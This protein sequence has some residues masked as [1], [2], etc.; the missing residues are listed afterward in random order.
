MAE[1]QLR[2]G[3]LSRRTFI[4]G[5]GAAA[6][7]PALATELM[8]CGGAG[9]SPAS[10]T[11]PA[12]TTPVHM[13]VGIVSYNPLHT[14]LIVAHE[15]DLMSKHNVSFDFTL[16]TNS[17]AMVAALV[18]GSVDVATASPESMF[19]IQA[20]NQDLQTIMAEDVGSGYSLI[21]RPEIGSISDLKGKTLGAS[22]AR[23]GP[24]T[25]AMRLML[26][27]HGLID[28]QD[29]SIIVIGTVAERVSAMKAKQVVAVAN[30]QPQVDQMIDA[31]F[32]V[33][34]D[35][36]NY[37]E[38]KNILSLV[39]AAKK[40][41]YQAHR[42]D[43]VRFVKGYVDSA[44]FVN[45]PA[46][47]DKVVAVLAKILKVD[48]RMATDAYDRFVGNHIYPSNPTVQKSPMDQVV[49]NARTLGLPGVPSDVTKYY[50]NSLVQAALK[51]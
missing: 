32:K 10:V 51:S 4:R 22:A 13:R 31:G 1:N 11:S 18:G 7:L 15:L 50:D 37:P 27:K 20:Q 26:R 42:D 48:T 29:Y 12:S 14:V 19:P 24:D 28:D 30:L 33:V 23:N 46:N 3:V 16:S 47:K 36:L 8:A 49:A 44:R 21:V 45:D 2:N 17:P 41:D 6:A 25:V 43:F 39:V 40:T 5:L 35:A 38:L 9:A 34:D